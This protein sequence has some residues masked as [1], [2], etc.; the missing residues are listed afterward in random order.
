VAAA[1]LALLVCGSV[2]AQT[3]L[4]LPVKERGEINGAPYA[5]QIPENWNGGLMIFVRGMV[6]ED[7][8]P[9]WQPPFVVL[10]FRGERIYNGPM[11]AAFE[12]GFAIAQ[13]T[14]SRKGWY[15]R[16]A[17][18]ETEMLRQHFRRTYGPTSPTLMSG[19][20]GGAVLNYTLME[21]YAD[22]YDGAIPWGGFAL[23]S[24]D[25]V[26]LAGFDLRLLFDH[27]FPGLPGSVVSFPEGHDTYGAVA[28][29]VPE[30]VK[31]NPEMLEVFLHEYHVESVERLA[32]KLALASEWLRQLSV[33][34]GL[35]N[36]FDNRK[37][38]YRIGPDPATL[39]R[40]VA[41]YQGD[42]RGR[43]Y[44][45][46]WLDVTGRIEAPILAVNSL[47]DPIMDTNWLRLYDH[48]TLHQ[49]TDHL[50]AQMWVD[51][52]SVSHTLAQGRKALDLLLE[53]IETGTPPESGELVVDAQ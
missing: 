3:E 26:K 4:E 47:Y 46:H 30:L 12:R 34:H 36:V 41:R 6:L 42:P 22:S 23:P 29:M 19:N 27:F 38:V 31:Q 48:L 1:A 17:A 43:E 53:W 14:Y 11:V 28:K 5:I 40:E 24:Y 37:T 25:G 39:N 13:C 35:G 32:R 51:K 18:I 16:E 15:L 44:L 8:K 49:G 21:M 10:P 9:M 45:L 52:E 2:L 50:Y 20:H 7:G 33:D